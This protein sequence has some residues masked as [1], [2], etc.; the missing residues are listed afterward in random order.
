MIIHVYI[1]VYALYQLSLG[2]IIYIFLEVVSRYLHFF[3]RWS[4]VIARISSSNS[5][6][7]TLI[8]VVGFQWIF[9]GNFLEQE[10]HENIWV[11]PK[12]GIP[13]NHPPF[14]R[15]FHYFHH[16]FWG[17]K[18]PYFWFNIHMKTENLFASLSFGE[19]KNRTRF[20]SLGEYQPRANKKWGTDESGRWEPPK[21][22]LD[23]WIWSTKF[24][25]KS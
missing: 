10:A 21:R 22:Q 5:E 13:A 9:S 6:S 18:S 24:G 23:N 25:P 20:R 16:P 12:I 1:Y 17:V 8:F 14:N 2:I 19:N 11:F 4:L 7:S 3:Q 15:V